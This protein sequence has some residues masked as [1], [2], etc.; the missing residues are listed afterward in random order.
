M[1]IMSIKII[2]LLFLTLT[3]NTFSCGS[4]FFDL[5]VVKPIE[6]AVSN[7]VSDGVKLLVDDPLVNKDEKNTVVE[8]SEYPLITT[9][10]LKNNPFLDQE[11]KADA[12][13][14]FLEKSLIRLNFKDEDSLITYAYPELVGKKFESKTN[15]SIVHT[16]EIISYELKF[17]RQKD[18]T[19]DDIRKK[20]GHK[21]LKTLSMFLKSNYLNID[22]KNS[23]PKSIIVTNLKNKND[24]RQGYWIVLKDLGKSK[25]A[26]VLEPKKNLLSWVQNSVF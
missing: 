23:S 6:H 21:P 3:T 17:R 19:V 9:E 12:P 7:T 26:V 25:K 11:K 14:N 24:N 13:Y 10:I 1:A 4:I 5:L 16:Y 8:L 22:R 20:Y 15:T 18:S 2:F